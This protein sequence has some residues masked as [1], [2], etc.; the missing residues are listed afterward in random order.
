MT[1]FNPAEIQNYPTLEWS[2]VSGQRSIRSVAISI[3]DSH[4]VAGLL[5]DLGIDAVKMK[6]WSS[7]PLS[8]NGIPQY[9]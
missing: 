4:V 8:A 5:K 7:V 9:F 2:V 3:R 6:Q 1:L